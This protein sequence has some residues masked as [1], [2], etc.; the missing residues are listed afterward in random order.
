MVWAF[1]HRPSQ[2]GLPKAKSS[3]KAVNDQLLRHWG[4]YAPREG[5]T[6]LP[7]F[8]K[9]PLPNSQVKVRIRPDGGNKKHYLTASPL[10]RIANFVSRDLGLPVSVGTLREE[11]FM[12]PWVSSLSSRPFRGVRDVEESAF[13]ELALSAPTQER[14]LY[15]FWESLRQSSAIDGSVDFTKSWLRTH[16]VARDPWCVMTP[17]QLDRFCSLKTDS[18]K[19]EFLHNLERT[20]WPVRSEGGVLLHEISYFDPESASETSAIRLGSSWNNSSITIPSVNNGLQ[21]VQY[22]CNHLERLLRMMGTCEGA[23]FTSITNQ[24]LNLPSSFDQE[25]V[26]LYLTGGSTSQQMEAGMFSLIGGAF[27]RGPNFTRL[28]IRSI[29]LNISKL[30]EKFSDS[31]E[32]RGNISSNESVAR[33]LRFLQGSMFR[34]PSLDPNVVEPEP[35]FFNSLPFPLLSEEDLNAM[36]KSLG[37]GKGVEPTADHFSNLLAVRL[38]STNRRLADLGYPTALIEKLEGGIFF[39]RF[40]AGSINVDSG[41]LS[42]YGSMVYGLYSSR[43]LSRETLNVQSGRPLSWEEESKDSAVLPLLLSTV[44][45]VACTRLRS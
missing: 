29:L 39:I 22:W 32:F 14:L 18:D 3:K 1:P 12:E 45:K 25:L 30:V 4:F 15:M 28:L 35:L 17:S 40:L 6:H 27:Q 13:L 43:K 31:E 21:S 16:R 38:G 10:K 2:R 44:L 7:L 34:A 33:G 42:Q 36:V 5:K 11:H 20:V 41:V 23:W 37:L 26:S 24:N 19:L 8:S 9:L